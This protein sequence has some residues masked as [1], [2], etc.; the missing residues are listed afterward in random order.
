MYLGHDRINVDIVTDDTGV[1]STELKSHP[2]ERLG[3]ASHHPLARQRRAGEADLP[4]ARVLRHLGAERIIIT[5]RLD[6]TRREAVTRQ[7]RQ[8]QAAVWGIRRR[9]HDNRV[10]RVHRTD[11][12]ENAQ[13]EGKVPGNNG[14]NHTNRRVSLDNPTIF[15]FLDD[16][17]GDFDL[18]CATGAG[19]RQGNLQSGLRE[20]LALLPGEKLGHGIFVGVNGV[21][22]G[23]QGRP[24]LVQGG[25]GPFLEGLLGGVDGT[26]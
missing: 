19:S 3:T 4:D 15:R 24:T 7:L 14:T 17:L 22:Q 20:R 12:L 21:C 26:I 8:L 9:L 10:A 6:N 2:L 13:G 18:G 23:T 11:D 5:Q 25:L 1:V 16:V